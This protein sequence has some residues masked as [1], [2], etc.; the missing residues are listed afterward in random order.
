MGRPGSGLARNASISFPRSATMNR[1]ISHFAGRRMGVK[2]NLAEL[3][4]F[5]F[6]A[7]QVPA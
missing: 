1:P 7:D 5:G 2:P 6:R 4:V 3:K